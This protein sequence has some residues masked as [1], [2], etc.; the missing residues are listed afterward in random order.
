[1]IRLGFL[2]PPCGAEDELFRYGEASSPDV[3]VTVIGTRIFG[4]DDEHAPHNL[5]RTGQIDNLLLSATVLARLK[6]HSVIWACTSGS[7]IDGLGHAKRQVDALARVTDCPASSTSLA[8]VEACRHLKADK[9]AVLASYP[10]ATAQ[11]F[12]SFLAQSGLEVSS[13]NWLSIGSGPQAAVSLGTGNLLNTALAMDLKGAQVLLI[14]DTAI[15]SWDVICPLE[16]RLGVPV[17]TANQVTLWESLR[18]ASLSAQHAGW[19]RLF[20]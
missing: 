8:F 1:M 19:G 2:Y 6:P 15:P 5:S 10:E 18:L 11:A 4:E 9:L 14:P 17:L 20:R 12:T 3:R 7:F 13:L 16:L